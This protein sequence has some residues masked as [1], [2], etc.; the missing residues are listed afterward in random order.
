[1]AQVQKACDASNLRRFGQIER[2][3][4]C[5]GDASPPRPER[6]KYPKLTVIQHRRAKD[7]DSAVIRH[8]RHGT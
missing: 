8:L 5:L 7:H 2:K 1:M 6:E 4:D 3:N